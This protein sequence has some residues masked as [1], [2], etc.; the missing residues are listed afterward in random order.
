MKSLNDTST[1]TSSSGGKHHVCDL[2]MQIGIVSLK[3]SHE[4]E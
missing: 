1:P 4:P 3:D 2:Q